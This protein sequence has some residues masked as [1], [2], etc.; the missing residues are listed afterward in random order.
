M[1][2]VKAVLRLER[3]YLAD[4]YQPVRYCPP[5]KDGCRGCDDSIIGPW[6]L[7]IMSAVVPSRGEALLFAVTLCKKCQGN[8]DR[9]DAVANEVVSGYLKNR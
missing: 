1:D 8:E 7:S 9:R 6:I 3:R 5:K 4:G 2:Q